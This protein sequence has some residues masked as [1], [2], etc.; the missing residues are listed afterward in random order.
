KILVAGGFGAGKTTFVGSA[1]EIPPLSTE[2]ILTDASAVT[3]SLTGVEGKTTTTVA[4]DFGRITLTGQNVVLMLFGMPG[5]Q[6]FDFLWDELSS[7]AM[8]AVILADTRQ[9]TS[10]FP[11]VDYFEKQH[12]PLA[13][14]VNHFD[15]SWC[16]S[17]EE[18][19]DALGLSPAV[20]VVLC[21]ARRT[22]S[23]EEVL[24]TLA[25]HALD[26]AT[27][28]IT[29]TARPSPHPAGAS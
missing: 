19:R 26:H 1:S 20:P 10:C 3:D 7:G 6:R 17:P 16:Y 21:D 23:A 11:A 12:L 2:E 9:L 18:V 15:H 5:Q 24:L 25:E 27:V 8:G 4:L 14:A 28:R 22:D 13:V 29:R